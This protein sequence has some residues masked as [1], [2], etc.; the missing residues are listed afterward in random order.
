M[1][2]LRGETASLLLDHIP[3]NERLN[4]VRHVTKSLDPKSSNADVQFAAV[5]WKLQPDE[6]ARETL[7][8]HLQQQVENG[9]DQVASVPDLEDKV[10]SRI[11]FT[12][13]R[14][15]SRLSSRRDGSQGDSA[16]ELGQTN[17]TTDDET[18][19]TPDA[20]IRIV[21]CLQYASRMASTELSETSARQLLE[22]CLSLLVATQENVASSAQE[23]LYALLTIRP[24]LSAAEQ[25]HLWEQIQSLA[26]SSHVGSKTIGFSLWLRWT[27]GQQV[28]ESILSQSA[29]WDL[30]VEGLTNGDSERRKS[31]LQ[32]L[33]S[34]VEV[35]ARSP[36]LLPMIAARTDTNIPCELMSM[37][38]V[39]SASI[40][41]TSGIAFPRIN[42]CRF[43]KSLLTDSCQHPSPSSSN[44]ADSAIH[45]KRSF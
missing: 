27:L 8:G 9:S 36:S 33:R 44:T 37:P 43:R 41:V 20:V 22:A 40:T 34:S 45:S 19:G 26:S 4:V 30:I 28:D 42:E 1:S 6:V 11:I 38:F 14:L 5:L 35:S 12:I 39:C 3:E 25:D 10:L 2:A 29:W 21:N 13:A 7:L 32:V 18:D 31:S 17:G 16:H 23:C 15:S 24:R